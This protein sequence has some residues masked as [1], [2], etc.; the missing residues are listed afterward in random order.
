MENTKSKIVIIEDEEILTDVLSKKLENEGYEVKTAPNGVIGMEIIQAEK[1][2]LVLLD[3]V[4]P[5]MNGY[6]V[7]TALNEA[8]GKENMPPVIIISNSGQPVEIDKARDLGAKDFIIKA[9]FTPEE[10]LE[11]VDKFLG[12]TSVK[13]DLSNDQKENIDE[14]N[15]EKNND[16]P[17]EA[18]ILIVEDDQFLRDLLK[19]KLEKENFDV[20]TAIDGPGGIEKITSV[21]PDVMLLDIILPGIDGFEVLKRIRTHSDVAVAKTPIILLSNL[22]QEADIEKGKALGANNYLIKS[23]FTIDEIIEKLRALLAESK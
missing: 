23:N 10:V 6:E 21:K 12:K 22:G 15:A 4:M 7:L 1:P 17:P 19:T 9:Q 11:K 20:N 16:T 2:D 18:R 14:G 5:K 13:S 8:F 3:I